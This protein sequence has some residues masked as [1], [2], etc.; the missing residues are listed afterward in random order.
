MH[1]KRFILL[2]FWLLSLPIA[3]QEV[4]VRGGFIQEGMKLGEPVNF[5]MSARY[6]G[7]VELLLPDSNYSFSPFEFAGRRYFESRLQDQTII[8][9]VVYTLQSYEID[10]VQYLD[11]PAFVLRS[12]DTTELR[13]STDSVLLFQLTKDV[14]DTTRL[15]ENLA[16]QDV[17]T[18]FNYP[19]W[20]IIF[21]GLAIVVVA[22]FLIFGGRI[23]RTLK[24]RKLRKEYRI[25]SEHLNAY[26]HTL[27]TEPEH[28]T[29]EKA[30]SEWKRFLETLEETPFSKLTTKEIVAMDYTSELRD[31]L[32]NIDRSVYGHLRKE[33]LYKDFQAVEDFT[34]HRYA[35]VTDRIKNG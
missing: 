17:P 5:W 24:L 35:V 4:Q 1:G 3:A 14:S 32:R 23:R 28:H 30:I 11:L 29:A 6:P 12:G 31:T 19:L 18:Y 8:D 2:L 27:K 33:D 16:Y 21:G 25:F 15:K 20:S 7:N 9:S 22:V 10:R 26:I 13:T 34:Q